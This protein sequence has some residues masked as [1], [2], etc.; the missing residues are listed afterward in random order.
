[1]PDKDAKRSSAEQE[2]AGGFLGIADDDW[3]RG[4]TLDRWA[5][6][7]HPQA[8]SVVKPKVGFLAAFRAGEP[9][10]SNRVRRG[11]DSLEEGFYQ[12]NVARL[13]TKSLRDDLDKGM[14]VLGEPP[15][16]S[17]LSAEP[18]PPDV[19]D[20]VLKVIDWLIMPPKSS[21]HDE[22][23][24]L[25]L[26]H[27]DRFG[28]AAERSDHG[29]AQTPS[30]RIQ[31]ARK[32]GEPKPETIARWKEDYE[33]IEHLMEV[34][35]CGP[36]N[37]AEFARVPGGRSANAIGRGHRHYRSFLNRQNGKNSPE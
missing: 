32:P 3:Q 6:L 33:T 25:R 21:L 17:R 8:Y 35:N 12:L 14:C 34:H 18:I 15:R 23:L 31:G 1:M 2:T 5:E 29:V 16:P 11:H 36:T 13:L 10:D 27:P 37:A 7:R 9:P 30:T 24:K 26:Y 19:L 20:D 22:T 4:V 28:G